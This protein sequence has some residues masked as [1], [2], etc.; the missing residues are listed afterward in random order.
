LRCFA[1]EEALRFEVYTPVGVT[2]AM[3]LRG[4]RLVGFLLIAQM[5]M[6]VQLEYEHELSP[7]VE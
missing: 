3:H 2:R 7:M 5:P 4:R 6:N 1:E